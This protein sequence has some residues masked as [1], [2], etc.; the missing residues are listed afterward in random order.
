MVENGRILSAVT[1][2]VNVESTGYLA[3]DTTDNTVQKKPS[4]IGIQGSFAWCEAQLK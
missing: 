2:P 3:T 4:Q 1:R